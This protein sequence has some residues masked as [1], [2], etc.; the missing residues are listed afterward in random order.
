MAKRK[1]KSR[2]MAIFSIIGFL[3]ILGSLF[4]FS[5]SFN[6]GGGATIFSIDSIETTGKNIQ[7]T[8][9]IIALSMNDGA[10]KITGE[11]TQE[12]LTK[13][14]LQSLPASSFKIDFELRNPTCEYDIA[15]A[16]NVVGEL[17]YAFV[18]EPCLANVC[19]YLAIDLDDVI[20][21]CQ[22][23]GGS[24]QIPA[25]SGE[26]CER[27]IDL[28]QLGG[29][30]TEWC[31]WLPEE[32]NIDEPGECRDSTISREVT[33][34]NN[35]AGC[36][37]WRETITTTTAKISE[38][39]TGGDW[40]VMSAGI[41]PEY[42]LFKISTAT[43]FG[44]DAV[45][46]VTMEETGETFECVIDPVTKA[47]ELGDFGSV[48][49][50]GNLVADKTCPV[51]GADTQ[52][53]RDIDSKEWT[54]VDSSIGSSLASYLTSLNKIQEMNIDYYTFTAIPEE[55]VISSSTIR[56]S[57]CDPAIGNPL[58]P[59]ITAM[60][61]LQ[62]KIPS[63]QPTDFGYTCSVEND[64]KYVCDTGASV[65]YP[66]LKLTVKADKVGI[67]IPDGQPEVQGISLSSFDAKK[68]D[69]RLNI[70]LDPN[71]I[72]KIYVGIK[73]IG[74][75]DDSFDV[76]LNCPFPVSQQSSRVSISAGS[77]EVAQLLVS[78]DGLIQDCTVDAVSVNYPSNKDQKEV[79]IVINPSCDQYGIQSNN[80]IMTEYGCFARTSYPST[81]CK[82][83]EFWLNHI[84]QCISYD[85]I[86]TGE[87][88]LE[89]LEQVA[90]TDC[91]R[92]CN[93]NKECIV[94]CLDYGNV[95][96][97]CTGIGKMMTL[98]DFLCDFEN[99]PNLVVPSTIPGKVW[100]DAPI[101]NYVC[102]FGKT[103]SDCQ[104]IINDVKFDYSKRPPTAQLISSD[105]KCE[106]CFDGIKNQDEE[107]I[108]CGGIC[109]E[110]YGKDKQCDKLR[111]PDH[112]FNSLQDGD[113]EG[114]DCGGSCRF[115]CNQIYRPGSS[116]DQTVM[117][118]FMIFAVI[119]IL[120]VIIFGLVVKR[121]KKRK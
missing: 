48:K 47:C 114:V 42:D 22:D 41:V 27:M 55:E 32:S 46:K 93:G 94:S 70:N 100:V 69:S 67:F 13:Y 37:R 12:T 56:G 96:P 14:N 119:I 51:P 99:Q 62:K 75:E 52:L 39:E 101:C 68:S 117:N 106:T 44:Y 38:G 89:I 11:I 60:N 79:P 105:A 26:D 29:S 45:V 5:Q 112:C 59:E 3:I 63:E 111:E 71:Q 72:E 120:L 61:G 74:S 98:N 116:T 66:L 15:Y 85:D 64:N 76:S 6:I 30:Y 18:T 7:D 115:S 84:E 19:P 108:D 102:E 58:F 103:G 36:G 83:N 54:E 78:G 86:S 34:T 43:E 110:K 33:V 8:E 109:E 87:Q 17:Y 73:N 24:T 107:D 16:D 40:Q 91:S 49:F 1:K 88:R 35:P 121:G 97:V 23:G 92:Q 113:E 104:K 81:P 4:Y 80:V 28:K 53:L 31:Y 2:N 57:G 65:V 21:H 50:A 77:T 118:Y 90:E 20:K 25:V 95:K 10:E 82:N 9:W